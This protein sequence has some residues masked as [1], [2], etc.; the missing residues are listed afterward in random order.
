VAYGILAC[1]AAIGE[2]GDLVHE[3]I[4]LPAVANRDEV[5]Q[6]CGNLEISEHM[7]EEQR[8]VLH[9]RDLIETPKAADELATPAIDAEP[10]RNAAK[11]ASLRRAER[12]HR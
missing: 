1:A 9:R 7:A 4:G 2:L 8:P 6:T 11:P 5:P 10:G 3:H 12:D